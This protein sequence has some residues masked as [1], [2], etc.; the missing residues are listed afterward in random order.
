MSDKLGS[1]V[2]IKIGIVTHDA[3]ATA[4]GFAAIF[5][6]GPVPA[7]QAAE[8][9][10]FTITPYKKYLG[11]PADEIKLKVIN[12]YTENFW[13]EIV[14]APQGT[15]SPWSDFL[16]KHGTSVCFTSIHIEDG[17]DHDIKVMEDAGFPLIFVEDKGYERYAYFDTADTLGLL[18]EVKERLAK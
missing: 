7:S 17:F 4:A 6:P 16:A 10:P 9:P 18:I 5:A 13:F 8:H 2:I 3:E 14:E 1:S 11:E 12:F 15:P